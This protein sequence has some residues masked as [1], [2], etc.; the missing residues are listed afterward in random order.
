MQNEEGLDLP[1]F[2]LTTADLASV[3]G[4]SSAKTINKGHQKLNYLI[5]FI[6]QYRTMTYT[7][8]P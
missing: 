4:T 6:V 8:F 2:P 7:I 5:Q 3:K 1:H